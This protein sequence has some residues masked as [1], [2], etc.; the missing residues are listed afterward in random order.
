MLES[1]TIMKT[2]SAV[3]AIR[4]FGLHKFKSEHDADGNL[5]VASSAAYNLPTGR[6]IDISWLKAASESYRISSNYKDYILTEVPIVTANV[7]NRNMDCFSYDELTFFNPLYGRM[8]YQTFVGKPTHVNHQN[9]DPKQA[10]GVIFDASLRKIGENYHVMILMGFDRT[11]DPALVKEIIESP[12]NGYSMGALVTYTTCS[13]D[14]F[15]SNGKTYCVN[16][17]GE[18]GCKKGQLFDGRISYE[19]CHLSN[20]IESSRVGS[21]ADVNAYSEQKLYLS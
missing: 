11:K 13:I 4:T 21:P 3:P 12:V 9:Q 16:H 8:T 6:P 20:Y 2:G 17:I 10:K 1:P 7:P 14:G 5:R 18:R 19:C 15:K